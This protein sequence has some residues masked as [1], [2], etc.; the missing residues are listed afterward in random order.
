MAGFWSTINLVFKALFTDTSSTHVSR[1][2]LFAAD[3]TAS[4]DA[5]LICGV[6]EFGGDPDRQVSDWLLTALQDVP[7][8]ALEG[9]E[10][11]FKVSNEGPDPYHGVRDAHFKALNSASR[12]DCDSV[13]W[14]EVLPDRA[15]IR[16]RFSTR[17]GVLATHELFLPLVHVFNLPATADA[18]AAAQIL[19]GI[20]ALRCAPVGAERGLELARLSS[21]LED[22]QDRINRGDRLDQAGTGV[23]TAYA[24]GA[25]VLAETGD[26]SYC[27][28]AIKVL[29][30][31]SAA[32]LTQPAGQE[33]DAENP[34]AMPSTGLA[35]ADSL[36]PETTALLALYGCLLN[37]SMV[38]N[39]SD[40]AGE[41][42]I[43]IWKLLERRFEYMAGAQTAQALCHARLGEACVAVAR[44]TEDVRRADDGI[45]H[46]RK[47][48]GLIKVK[49]QAALY[50]QTAYGLGDA[51]IAHGELSEIGVPYDKVIPVFQAAL[52]VCSRRDNPY[53]WGRAM[54]ALASAQS[55]FGWEEKDRSMLTMARNNFAHAHQALDE[56]GARGAARAASGGYMRAENMLEKIGPDAPDTMTQK[57]AS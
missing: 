34:D 46:F 51:M 39:A 17:N 1:E 11:A 13:F 27:L 3:T 12:R 50:A 47:S 9:V 30:P 15:Q 31:L 42:A 26:R 37:W 40:R 28:T 49:T 21:R 16:V 19:L 55:A 2:A 18:S 35:G 24:W 43:E 44:H 53:L 22:L 32:C 36:T 8:V 48:I 7:G 10:G 38:S 23:V 6:A 25:M 5:R 29:E 20:E 54:F 33:Q 57:A 56:A 4:T 45:N 14:G 52:K 41:T